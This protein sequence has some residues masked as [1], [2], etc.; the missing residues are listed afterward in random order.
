M[1][2]RLSV[3]QDVGGR[4]QEVV[5]RVMTMFRDLRVSQVAAKCSFAR[6]AEIRN[7]LV[8]SGLLNSVRAMD[9]TVAQT[10]TVDVW[11]WVLNHRLLLRTDKDLEAFLKLGSQS[12][13]TIK[14]ERIA[15]NLLASRIR[16]RKTPK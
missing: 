5:R 14:R 13:E 7:G 3:S 6:L 4:T 2:E 9:L 1:L 11:R 15:S 16:R 10:L 8:H 12:E